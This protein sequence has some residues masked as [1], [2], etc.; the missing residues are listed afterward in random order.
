MCFLF[1]KQLDI[2]LSIFANNNFPFYTSYIFLEFTHKYIGKGSCAVL[3][4][5]ASGDSLLDWKKIVSAIILLDL[6]SQ[7]KGI[8]R[9]L[10]A[11]TQITHCT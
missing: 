6:F 4:G 2:V 3:L 8:P 7:L 5:R 9:L 10:K 1:D 11:H